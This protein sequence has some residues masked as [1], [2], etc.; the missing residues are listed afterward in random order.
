MIHTDILT[1][2]YENTNNRQETLL[3]FKE[4]VNSLLYHFNSG[5]TEHM[6][7]ELQDQLNQ[8]AK[9]S[10]LCPECGQETK[11]RRLHNEE[12]DARGVLVR[13]PLTE[14]HCIHCGWVEE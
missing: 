12:V 10:N 7:S 14:M 5:K 1:T 13:E 3:E 6:I 9:E 8:F 11:T 4:L 2:I